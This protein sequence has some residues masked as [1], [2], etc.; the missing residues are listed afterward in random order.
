MK[1]LL[2]SSELIIT[3]G[4]AG[5]VIITPREN[6]EE[7]EYRLIFDPEHM[8]GEWE[9]KHSGEIIN[10]IGLGSSFLAGFAASHCVKN[11]NIR[12]SVKVGLNTVM[13]LCLMGS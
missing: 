10:R 11:L 1:N 7:N 4:S 8:E 2:N 6:P 5:A 12:D 13:L 9:E 3:I